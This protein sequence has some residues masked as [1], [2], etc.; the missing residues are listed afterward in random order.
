MIV[1]HLPRPNAAS[2]ESSPSPEPGSGL[3]DRVEPPR[4]ILDVT[5]DHGA[6][7]SGDKR[8]LAAD[9]TRAVEQLDESQSP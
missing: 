2:A 4:G 1:M 9:T 3:G 7:G 8:H 5:D 6:D